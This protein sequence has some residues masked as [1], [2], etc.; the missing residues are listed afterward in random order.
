MYNSSIFFQ[1]WSYNAWKVYDMQTIWFAWGPFLVLIFWIY[2]QIITG[3]ECSWKFS[4]ILLHGKCFSAK[5]SCHIS[6]MLIIGI[7]KVYMSMLYCEINTIINWRKSSFNM[8]FSLSWHH[9]W[10]MRKNYRSHFHFLV[11][12]MKDLMPTTR[13]PWSDST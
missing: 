8:H 2:N 6:V 4:Y 9:M 1:V 12:G 7:Y 10:Q 5:F 11:L 3:M 13:Y